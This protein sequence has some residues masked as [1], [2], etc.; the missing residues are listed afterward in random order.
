MLLAAFFNRNTNLLLFKINLK[1]HIQWEQGVVVL[2]FIEVH[3]YQ[4]IE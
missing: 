4:E 3:D 1:N 2:V